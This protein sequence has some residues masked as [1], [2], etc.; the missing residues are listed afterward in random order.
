M[1]IQPPPMPG[2]H[3]VLPGTGNDL[4][5][6]RMTRIVVCEDSHTYAFA[7]RRALEYG[8]RCS[9]VGVFPTAEQTL[10]ALPTLKPDLVTMDL[11]LPGMS[12]LRAVEQIMSAQ[13]VP[14]LVLSAHLPASS[15]EPVA[16]ASA[17]LSLKSHCA[18]ASAFTASGVAVICALTS[19]ISPSTG[20]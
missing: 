11:E 16:E 9:V 8:G 19:R 12:G 10:A 1:S 7:L 14:I 3:L 20:A 2:S 15:S 5:D 13:P 4:G 17:G 18:Y 6:G